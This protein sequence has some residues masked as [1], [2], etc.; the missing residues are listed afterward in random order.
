MAKAKQDAVA[1][2]KKIG[3]PKSIKE[4]RERIE[5]T[6]TA[7]VVKIKLPDGSYEQVDKLAAPAAKAA[8]KKKE[9]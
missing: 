8:P 5:A 2:P 3:E 4:E 1:A 9:V 7:S 6:R